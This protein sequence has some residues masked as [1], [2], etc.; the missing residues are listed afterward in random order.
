MF[1]ALKQLRAADQTRSIADLFAG[2]QD[3]ADQFSASLGDLHFDY[4]KTH[5]DAAVMQ[6]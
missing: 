2:N 6:A 4:S 5:I 1:E 3:R